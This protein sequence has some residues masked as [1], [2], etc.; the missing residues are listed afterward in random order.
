MNSKKIELR[1]PP[2]LETEEKQS[3]EGT[4][5]CSRS[6]RTRSLCNALRPGSKQVRSRCLFH[7]ERT[8]CS[9]VRKIA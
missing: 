7:K 3:P 9:D 2:H 1:S 6:V 4:E 8:C 5:L